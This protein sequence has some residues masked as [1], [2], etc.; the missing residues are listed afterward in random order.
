[1]KPAIIKF[2]FLLIISFFIISSF[3]VWDKIYLPLS[4]NAIQN[5]TGTVYIKNNYKDVNELDG[6]VIN[7][8][9]QVKK[10]N[11]KSKYIGKNFV[12]DDRLGE[13]VTNDIISQCHQCN[14]KSDYH[15]NCSNDLCHLL[16]IQCNNCNS[17]FN[18]CCSKECS[19]Y[20]NLD[21]DEKNLK[22]KSFLKYNEKRLEGK[23]K[24]K[25][26]NIFS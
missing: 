16:F 19:D 11:I 13:R 23:V 21:E 15:K 2:L 24:P 25:L 10:K 3:Y 22:K 4:E 1:M 5:F 6:G 17:I 9:H 12:F 26:Y 20:I 18:G 7:Y 14:N 8:A